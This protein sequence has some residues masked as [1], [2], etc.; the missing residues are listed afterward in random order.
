LATSEK[1]IKSMQKQINDLLGSLFAYQQMESHPVVESTYQ[2]F[3]IPNESFLNGNFLGSESKSE[4]TPLFDMPNYGEE[5]NFLS[6]VEPKIERGNSSID[7]FLS[8]GNTFEF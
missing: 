2:D 7:G 3:S 8:F 6:A 5:M 4:E 1:I